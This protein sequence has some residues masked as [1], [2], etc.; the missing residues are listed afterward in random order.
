[1]FDTEKIVKNIAGD[2]YGKDKEKEL[3]DDEWRCPKC[4]TVNDKYE[5]KV[6]KSCQY[7]RKKGE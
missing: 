4:G 5:N 1:M 6:C 3:E 7:K 2:I